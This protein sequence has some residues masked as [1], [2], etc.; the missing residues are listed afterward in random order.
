MKEVELAEC[1]G[2]AREHLREMRAAGVLV[3]GRHWRKDGRHVVFT[4]EGREAA[5]AALGVSD[6]GMEEI[7]APGAAGAEKKGVV[8]SFTRNDRILMAEVEGE[9]VRVAVNSARNFVVGMEIPVVRRQEDLFDLVGRCP[10]GR[11]RW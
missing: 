2:V 4:E 3:Q 8:A 6:A 10:R 9:V 11:G 1:V 5:C 7:A